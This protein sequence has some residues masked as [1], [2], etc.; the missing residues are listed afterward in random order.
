[1]GNEAQSPFVTLGADMAPLFRK[2]TKLAGPSFSSITTKRQTLLLAE[3]LSGA[4]LSSSQ[5]CE[6][7]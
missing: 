6:H 7:Q 2:A 1:M 5:Q 4:G 3:D